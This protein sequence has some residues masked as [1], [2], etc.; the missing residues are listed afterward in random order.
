[1]LTL[2]SPEHKGAKEGHDKYRRGK[3]IV[4]QDLSLPCI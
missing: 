2:N 1:M 4:C 3:G